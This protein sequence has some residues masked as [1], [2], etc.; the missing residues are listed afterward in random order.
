M[1]FEISG[2]KVMAQWSQV[3]RSASTLQRILATRAHCTTHFFFSCNSGFSGML[4]LGGSGSPSQ[5][6]SVTC[7]LNLTTH[8]THINT[9]ASP[10]AQ[11]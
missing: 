10:S 9:H 11:R 7:A 8:S 2:C 3:E 4:V 6:F 1:P 5:G